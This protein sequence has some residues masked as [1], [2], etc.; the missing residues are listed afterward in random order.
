MVII[1]FSCLE[2]AASLFRGCRGFGGHVRRLMMSGE[3]LGYVWSLIE[4]KAAHADIMEATSVYE[5]V[6]GAAAALLSLTMA[7]ETQ[8]SLSNLMEVTASLCRLKEAG[9]S[10][11]KISRHHNSL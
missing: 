7:S 3:Y 11:Q 6:L 1:V 4:A 10:L 8:D 9:H 5:V 2:A